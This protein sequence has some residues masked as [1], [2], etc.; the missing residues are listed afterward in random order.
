MR[1]LNRWPGFV[2]ARPG[3]ERVVLRGM[4]TALTFGL[5]IL[6]LPSILSR[7]PNVSVHALQFQALTSRVELYTIGL[8]VCYCNLMLVI[9][10][11]AVIVKLMKGPVFVADSYPLPDAD[12]PA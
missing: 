1:S 12:E 4:P 8:L 5:A 6:L 2:P 3:F 9:A 11:G 7:L 10:I